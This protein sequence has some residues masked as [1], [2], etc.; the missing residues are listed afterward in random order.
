M[1]SHV[2]EYWIWPYRYFW[3]KVNICNVNCCN[4]N[5]ACAAAFMLDTRTSEYSFESVKV[6]ETENVSTWGGLESQTFWLMP[7]A[8]TYRA[9]R[10]RHLLSHVFE[11]WIWPYRYFW[12]KITICNV[13]CC[14]VN[15]AWAAAFMLDTRTSEYSFERVKVFETENVSTWG[16]LES[17]NFEL[18]PN[19][20]TYWAK[21]ARHLLSHVYEYWLWWYRYF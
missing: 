13:N 16:G 21:R 3:S 12:S 2:F 20:L 4:V 11:Y 14:N 7:N 8:L 1:L 19:A 18:M 17:P 10:A 5:C 6:F 15:C 9:I